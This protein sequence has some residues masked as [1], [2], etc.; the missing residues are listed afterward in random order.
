M[1]NKIVYKIGTPYGDL[2]ELDK[3]GNVIR[4]S[5]GLDKSNASKAEIASWGKW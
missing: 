3:D 4:Y 5:N 1:K 2:Y